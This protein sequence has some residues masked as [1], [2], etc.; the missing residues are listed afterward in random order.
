MRDDLILVNKPYGATPLWCIGELRRLGILSPEE[1]ATYA[2]RLDPLATGLLLIL[3]GEG[4]HAKNSFLGFTKTYE[5]ELAFGAYT[6]TGDLLGVLE[7]IQEDFYAPSHADLS[8]ALSSITEAPYPQFSS[9]P[10][11][12]TALHESGRNG[13]EA[14]RPLR[15]MSFS[16]RNISDA[17][18]GSFFA[19]RKRTDEACALVQGDFRQEIISDSWHDV[20]DDFPIHSLEMTI[21]VTSGT[22]IRSIPEIL[23]SE[24]HIPSVITKIHRTKVGEFELGET[25][26]ISL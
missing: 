5:I 8:N 4:V 12:G 26:I 3:K 13:E 1:K 9:K 21:D 2:G 15:E 18:P 25:G 20:Q 17:T 7:Y 23:F 19:L 10:V 6:D 11:N 22:Y 16:V 14:E 24:F